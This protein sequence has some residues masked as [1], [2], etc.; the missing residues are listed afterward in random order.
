[1]RCGRAVWPPRPGQP[2]ADA[3][4]PRAVIGP[5]RSPTWP[6]S[7]RGSQCRAKM[8]S[9]PSSAAGRDDG[10]GAAGHDLLGRLEQQPDPAGQLALA[11][12]GRRAR[13]RRRGRPRCARRGRRRGRRPATVERVRARPCRRRTGSASRSARSATVRGA[14]ARRRT[15]S[16]V[17]SGS[18]RRVQPGRDQALAQ[19]RRVVRTSA[20]DSSGWACRSRRRATSSS[21][22]PFSEAS[23][24]RRTGRTCGPTRR[25]RLTRPTLTRPRAATVRSVGRDVDAPDLAQRVA[26]LAD[27]GPGPQRLLHRVQHVVGALGRRRAASSRCRSTRRV[28]ARRR[29]APRSR[30]R[31]LAPRSPGRPAAARTAPRR[32]RANRLT[33]TTTRSPASISCATSVRRPL[34]LALLEALLDRG[35]RAAELL[36]AG[37]QLERAPPRRRRSSTRRR[38]SRRTGRRSRSRRSRRRA[39][40]GCAARAGRP[41]RSAAR[42]PRRR[43]WCAATGCR[44]APRRAPARATR[45]RLTSGC[46]AVSCTPAVW[47]WK[48]SISDFGF[49]APNSSRITCAQ[50]RRAARNFAT[51]SSSVVRATKKNDS[52]GRELVDVRARPRARRGRTRCRWR[53]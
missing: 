17:P 21:A 22:Q 30:S 20:Q 50:I 24:A 15:T 13:A 6:T 2:H 19:R 53:A 25:R 29:A 14:L 52:R 42:S 34:D 47:V 32:R 3:G 8:R 35:D 43:S 31:L 26:H 38:T 9:T 4:R 48:R 1:M 49:L 11:V 16:P 40:A 51:S 39:P 23:R 36:D 33:P 41:S 27:G 5:S 7:R 45:T 18:D 10:E 44:R 28:V 37:H 46:C 12:P